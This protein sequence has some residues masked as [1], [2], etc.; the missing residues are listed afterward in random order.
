M[1]TEGAQLHPRCA[2]GGRRFGGRMLIG[3][4]HVVLGRAC[5]RWEAGRKQ[6]PAGTE[7]AELGRQPGI[8]SV[9]GRG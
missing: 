1:K 4:G 2:P 9:K 7:F 6:D 3:F 8:D 5:E